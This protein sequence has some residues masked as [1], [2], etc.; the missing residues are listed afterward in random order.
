MLLPKL[1]TIDGLLVEGIDKVAGILD[2]VLE[3][4]HGVH[5][6]SLAPLALLGSLGLV[7]QLTESGLVWAGNTQAR[8]HRLKEQ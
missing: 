7:L 5:A 6:A 1:I 8:E 4:A 2:G 3:V